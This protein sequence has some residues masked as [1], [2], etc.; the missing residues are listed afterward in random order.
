MEW[1]REQKFWVMRDGFWFKSFEE[2][3][4]YDAEQMKVKIIRL[5][6]EKLEEMRGDNYK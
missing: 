6:N 2:F 1:L 3:F 5:I 4:G